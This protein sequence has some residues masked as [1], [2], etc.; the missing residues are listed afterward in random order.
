MCIWTIGPLDFKYIQM[1]IF[2]LYYID[3]AKKE[4]IHE[5]TPTSTLQG[6]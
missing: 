2:R 4:E 5:A 1:V 6:V 3:K